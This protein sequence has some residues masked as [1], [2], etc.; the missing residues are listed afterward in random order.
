MAKKKVTKKTT[1]T[2]V[3]FLLD[4][5]G[6]M[7]YVKDATISGFNE[8]VKSLKENKKGKILMTLTKFN[9][10]KID[11]VYVNK[12]IESVECLDNKNYK[13]D[14]MT[15]LYD[16]IGQTIN[17]SANLLGKEKASV[18]FV[19]MTDGEENSSKEHTQESIKKLVEEKEKENWTFIYLGADHDSWAQAQKFGLHRGN[20]KDFAKGQ[21]KNR[22]TS[23]GASTCNF[24]AAG[25]QSATKSFFKDNDEK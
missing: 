1:Q 14:M 6:S 7:S 24:M 20:V 22:M 10:H 16:A 3:N 19:I 18:L 21:I 25:G 12:E 8:Y 23:L 4:E 15:P 11:T 13:P 5:T 9:S 17:E 2:I